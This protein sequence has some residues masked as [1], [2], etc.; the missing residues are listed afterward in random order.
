MQIVM[1]IY[2]EPSCYTTLMKNSEIKVGKDSCLNTLNVN[3]RVYLN[4]SVSLL[5]SKESSLTPPSTEGI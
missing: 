3:E 5:N 4:R 2:S 1:Y